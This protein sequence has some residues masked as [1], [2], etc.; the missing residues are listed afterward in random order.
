MRTR[1]RL[2][3]CILSCLLL[4]LSS[5]IA[6]AIDIPFSS[7]EVISPDDDVPDR[8]R[9]SY[10]I[11]AYTDDFI[12]NFRIAEKYHDCEFE[13]T[14]YVESRFDAVG[15]K[16]GIAILGTNGELCYVTEFGIFECSDCQKHFARCTDSEGNWDKDA[17]IHKVLKKS[18][19]D[20]KPCYC[21]IC[22]QELTK[23]KIVFQPD[24]DNFGT[25]IWQN[26]RNLTPIIQN[27]SGADVFLYLKTIMIEAKTMPVAER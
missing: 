10:Q 27:E 18:L 11:P 24:E 1:K 23:G 6:Q 22:K 2:F 12:V 4:I 5:S 20:R 14:E 25:I 17:H 9:V 3:V 21:L 15:S 16:D 7:K 8:F 26:K 19:T 13:T